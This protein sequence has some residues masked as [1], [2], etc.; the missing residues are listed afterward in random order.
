MKYG[1]N[2]VL[3]PRKFGLLVGWKFTSRTPVV[4]APPVVRTS[5]HPAIPPPP[6]SFSLVGTFLRPAGTLLSI[7]TPRTMPR[8]VLLPTLAKLDG[9]FLFRKSY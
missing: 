6:R 9:F 5:R 1:R 2:F 3:R 7:I 4:H 8:A